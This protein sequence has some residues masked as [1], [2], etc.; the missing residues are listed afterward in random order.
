MLQTNAIKPIG[1][2]K[3][4]IPRWE[5]KKHAFPNGAESYWI[6][7]KC[8]PDD[9]RFFAYPK[10][11][12]TKFD[13]EF[14]QSGNENVQV[15][16]TWKVTKQ[17]Y[18]TY[19]PRMC[20]ELNF[21]E[22]MYDRE[23]ELIT[24]LFRIKYF[25]D[26]DSISYG[27]RNFDAFRDFCYKT[28]FTD[29]MKEKIVRCV[30]ENYVD[31]IE[32]DNMMDSRNPDALAVFAK[33]RR[34]LEFLNV[35][36]KAML[37]VSYCIKIL[38]F[39]INHF[40]VMRG[41]NVQKNI[42]LFYRF[43][44]PTFT[45]FGWEFDIFNKIYAYTAAKVAS[46]MS[47]NRV[48]FEQQEI[49]G[50]DKSIIIHKLLTENCVVDKLVK[51]NLPQTWNYAKG[52]P[53]ERVLSFLASIVNTHLSIFI[54]QVF[55]RNL[56]EVS[57]TV[58]ADGNSK[59]DRYRASKMKLNEEYVILASMD[60]HQ[61]V[62]KLYSDYA[63]EITPEEIMYYRRNLQPSRL[64]QL[65]VEIYFFNYTGSSHEF[66]IL[67]NEDL[68]KLLLIM[69]H[70]LMRRLNVKRSTII[71]SML[72]LIITA[73][74]EENPVGEKVYMKDTKFL[75]KNEDYQLLASRFYPTMLDIDPDILK[76]MLITFANAKYRFVVH[77]H[78]DLLGQEISIDKYELMQQL[79]TFLV[80]ANT[81]ITLENLFNKPEEDG[82]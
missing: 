18:S 68:F 10:L 47:Y 42:D 25:I 23:G 22:A 12:V 3:E 31:D 72:T 60:M 32:A 53:K 45:M 54:M 6:R 74:I 76:R 16:N 34:T 78:P 69:R 19:L 63:N 40:C 80:I 56:I 59:T 14:C 41:I 70:D 61:L 64:Q 48:I 44:V 81:S 82:E 30:D 20:E 1:S 15:L 79:L 13:E 26:A 21:F 38:S 65:M 77:E 36:V 66:S 58:D 8:H 33:K 24:A 2:K 28:I 35:H 62:S 11:L 67:R 75:E 50:R 49:E 71:D 27:E 9:E 39:I 7:W 17:S 51:F 73:N 52:Q 46:S 57:M 43:Y 37:T 29:T 5:Y 4:E 55:R